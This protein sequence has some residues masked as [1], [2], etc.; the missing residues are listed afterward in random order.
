MEDL[1]PWNDARHALEATAFEGVR[2]V[3]RTFPGSAERNAVVW[4]GVQ[5]YGAVV[6]PEL[7]RLRTELAKAHSKKALGRSLAEMRAFAGRETARAD[8]AE[9][10]RDELRRMYDELCAAMSR[11]GDRLASTV[12]ERDTL[13]ADHAACAQINAWYVKAEAAVERVRARCRAEQPASAYD[14]TAYD[15]ATDILAALDTPTPAEE[16]DRG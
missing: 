9:A 15:L 4:R 14:T 2:E 5:A 12:A 6:G 8:R 16:T 7:E 13:K 11:T 1:T 10:E 3:L